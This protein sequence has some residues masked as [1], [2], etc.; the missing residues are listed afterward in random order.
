MRLRVW[1]GKKIAKGAFLFLVL[2]NVSTLIGV[3]LYKKVSYSFNVLAS[4]MFIINAY[5]VKLFYSRFFQYE[6]GGMQIAVVVLSIVIFITSIIAL[7][8]DLQGRLVHKKH[9]EQSGSYVKPLTNEGDISMVAHVLGLLSGSHYSQW[10]P[11][12]S[13]SIVYKHRSYKSLILSYFFSCVCFGK[14]EFF[15]K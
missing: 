11:D 14:R 7:V 6:I 1:D 13:P 2:G 12:N 15:H 10:E 8:K 4:I 3:C 9:P 5:R